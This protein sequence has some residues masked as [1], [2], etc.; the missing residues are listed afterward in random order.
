MNYERKKFYSESPRCQLGPTIFSSLKTY[1]PLYSKAPRRLAKRHSA[2]RRSP[3]EALS[4]WRMSQFLSHFGEWHWPI[5]WMPLCRML[6][7]WMSWRRILIYDWIKGSSWSFCR[8]SE[9]IKKT[10]TIIGVSCLSL[11]ANFILNFS[12]IV[13]KFSQ[14]SLIMLSYQT[15][16][17]WAP[18]KQ[19]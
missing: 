8:E 16:W 12:E 9:G 13:V 11:I 1:N 17:V 6:S 2:E 19:L 3:K 18:G 4:L 5:G 7:Y 10:I 14:E 15:Y